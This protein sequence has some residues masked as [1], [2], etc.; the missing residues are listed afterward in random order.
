MYRPP[1]LG[2]NNFPEHYL[3]GVSAK[4]APLAPG[5]KITLQWFHAQMAEWY[6]RYLEEV[7]V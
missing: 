1:R 6:T 2:P 4:E 5:F 3:K 7:V